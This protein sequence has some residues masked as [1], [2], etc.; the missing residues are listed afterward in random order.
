MPFPPQPGSQQG[1]RF[2]VSQI[3]C[4][5]CRFHPVSTDSIPK[6]TTVIK[7]PVSPEQGGAGPPRRSREGSGHG[8]QPTGKSAGPPLHRVSVRGGLLGARPLAPPRSGLAIPPLVSTSTA[9][10]GS[11]K[12]PR[13]TT[14]MV[15][16][17]CPCGEPAPPGPERPPRGPRPSSGTPGSPSAHNACAARATLHRWLVS[18]PDSH[19]AGPPAPPGAPRSSLLRCPWGHGDQPGASCSPTWPPLPP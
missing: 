6:R 1:P 13:V 19:P 8:P 2:C 17:G 9:A 16:P 14:V 4:N 3:G 11:G 5:C 18:A 12:T 7:G 15:H 10:R